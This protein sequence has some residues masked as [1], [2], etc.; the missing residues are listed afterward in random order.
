MNGEEWF[1]ARDKGAIFE[2]FGNFPTVHVVE[3]RLQILNDRETDRLFFG[4][5]FFIIIFRFYGRK[6]FV[7][8]IILWITNLFLLD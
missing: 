3:R 1:N 2:C 6:L 4:N 8:V 7:F 5:R